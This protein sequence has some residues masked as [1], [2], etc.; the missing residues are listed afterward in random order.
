MRLLLAALAF[1]IFQTAA[2]SPTFSPAWYDLKQGAGGQLTKI[3]S[4]PAV[5]ANPETFLTRTDTYGAYIYKATGACTYGTSQSLTAPCW[6]QLVT[7]SSIPSSFQNW[8]TA[9][10]ALGVS[11]TEVVA[12][13]SNTDVLYMLFSGT[14]L[15][16]TDRGATWVSTTQA[17]TATGSDGNKF[18]GPFM[19][20]DPVNPDIAYIGI[21]NALRKTI[22]GRSGASAA[23]CTVGVASGACTASSVGTTGASPSAICYDP[24]SSVVS[25]VTQ[26]F[27][28]FTYSTGMYETS[29][30][31][32]TWT[33]RASGGPTTYVH[34]HCDKFGQVWV[35]N[36]GGSI[37]KFASGSWSTIAPTG[38]STL[39]SISTDPNSASLGAN[40]VIAAEAGGQLSISTDNGGSF[41]NP[42]FPETIVANGASAPPQPGWIN[43]AGQGASTYLSAGGVAI[44]S[45]S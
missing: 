8:N 10:S 1:A 42:F 17:T 38:T 5:G 4:Y 7:T 37:F 43:V 33:S 26:H 19:A 39:G 35:V 30:G 12:A 21:N 13:K 14:L 22:N 27:F 15:V 31:G 18:K 29:D 32:S 34:M 40:K 28:V 44:D 45:T 2:S 11:V 23:F 16:S 3:W 24:T 41:S 20:V 25:S 9:V 36:G 6:Q